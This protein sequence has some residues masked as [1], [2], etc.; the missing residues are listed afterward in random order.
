[1]KN[2]E[3]D[4]TPFSFENIH[5]EIEKENKLIKKRDWEGLIKYYKEKLAQGQKDYCFKISEVYIT[6]LKQYQ[7]AI[8]FLL[9]I[10][11]ENPSEKSIQQEIQTAKNYL[12]N[13]EIHLLRKDF[14]LMG[15]DDM[16][17]LFFYELP[18]GKKKKFSE[19]LDE[20]YKKYDFLSVDINN[21]IYGVTKDKKV[22][23]NNEY[24]AYFIAND[25][26]TE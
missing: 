11:Q 12:E 20:L 8:D 17:R 1:M 24:D 10:Q 6:E 16:F 14:H 3:L 4:K 21:N 18:S 19:R 13:K 23:L 22:L 5:K 15:E 7:K 26:I 2:K 25:L 9:P